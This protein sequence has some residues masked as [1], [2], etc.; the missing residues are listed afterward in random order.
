MDLKKLSSVD[1]IIGVAGGLLAI[2][3]IALPWLDFGG[4]LAGSWS[5]VEYPD[6][7]LEWLA[8]LIGLAMVAQ[9]V[10]SKLTTVE[11]PALGI[12]WG[13]LKMI[14]GFAALA[15]VALKFVLHLHPSYLGIGCWV[16]IVLA[17]ALAYGGM[18]AAKEPTGT[19]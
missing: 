17:V 3:L 18:M 7:F 14:G 12:S 2:D 15:L 6:G 5:G 10:L 16:G 4:Y 8:V 13:K 9:V 19:V 1:W 11:L